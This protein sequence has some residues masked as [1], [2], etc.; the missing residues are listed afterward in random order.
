LW[1]GASLGF[2]MAWILRQIVVG[3]GFEIFNIFNVSEFWVLMEIC[4][5]CFLKYF[6]I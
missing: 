2:L 6:F 4:V 3:E 1:W 5:G